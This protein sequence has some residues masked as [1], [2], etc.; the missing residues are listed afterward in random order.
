MTTESVCTTVTAHLASY[1]HASVE[2]HPDEGGCVIITPFTYP[3]LASIELY[4]YIEGDAFLLTDEGE[5]LNML[6]VNGLTLETKREGRAELER[7]AHRYQVDFRD[8]AFSVRVR[9]ADLGG[10]AHRLLNALQA[11]GYLLYRKQ[12]R[13]RPTINEE[14]EGTLAEF[15]VPYRQ[16]VEIRGLKWKHTFNYYINS[17]KNILIDP[18][19]ATSIGS[20]RQKAS[21]LAY[22]AMDLHRGAVGY[23]V[24]AV[25][26]DRGHQQIWN[27]S[28][29][30]EPLS[31]VDTVIKWSSSRSDFVNLLTDT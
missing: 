26:D 9:E 6:Y 27:N 4:V 17:T 18:L 2:G 1:L 10:A 30:L 20:G 19:S 21:I 24:I 28:D 31:Y 16:N 23:R 5:T 7:I 12:H 14:I 29:V 11:V 8:A 13:A 22:K 15:R 3:D 25:V